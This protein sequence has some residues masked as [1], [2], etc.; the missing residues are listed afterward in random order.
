MRNLRR[1]IREESGT[2]LL[3]SVLLVTLLTGAAMAAV[4]TTSVNQNISEN[5]LTS[6]QAFYRADAGIQ[7]AKIFL[8]QNQ[9]NWNTYASAQ[10]QTLLPYTALASTGGYSV[11]VQD[12]GGGSLLIIST[13]TASGNAQTV[14]QSLVARS[15]TTYSPRYAFV[16]GNNFKFA[17][18]ASIAGTSC[19]VHANGD[20]TITSSPTI[21]ADAT[22]SGAYSVTGTPIISGTTG[23][24]KP[25]EPIPVIQPADFYAYRDWLLTSVGPDGKVYDKNNVLLATNTWN[26]WT[27]NASPPYWRLANSSPLNGT[28]YV[29]GNV[30]ITGHSA[31][32][33]TNNPWIATI[34][35][36]GSIDVEVSTNLTVRAP[37]PT[38]GSLYHP[39]TKDILFLAGRD[40][41]IDSPGSGQ[42]FQ[43]LII[44]YEQVS[45]ENPTP[46]LTGAV[47]AQDLATVSAEV[48]VD[49]GIRTSLSLTYNGN[50]GFP[51][52]GVG[53]VQLMTWQ[54]MR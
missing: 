40:V 54:V 31:S 39:E 18:A 26:G 33:V 19:G 23:G 4:M 6:K 17:A 35:A 13:G 42:S 5:I 43:G 11:T 16:T 46:F 38:D 32:G 15:G 53:P 25:L 27:Y 1:H 10:A 51:L 2:A 50:M 44:A 22:A 21:S 7:H 37:L 36:T 41:E 28:H 9:G 8:T 20:L 47:I 45:I 52:P 34:I 12:G 29:V 30:W 3:A 48:D 14:I 24:G 49:S